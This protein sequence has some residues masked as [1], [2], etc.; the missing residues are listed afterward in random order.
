M[1]ELGKVVLSN[2]TRTVLLCYAPGWLAKARIFWTVVVLHPQFI[3]K[4]ML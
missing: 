4:E 1:C 3:L 2:R